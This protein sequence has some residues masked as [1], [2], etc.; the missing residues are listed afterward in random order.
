[1]FELAQRNNVLHTLPC[2][3]LDEMRAAYNFQDLQ[4]FLDLYYAGCAALIKEQV[5]LHFQLSA[6]LMPAHILQS[7]ML[8]SPLLLGG[9][10]NVFTLEIGTAL[11]TRTLGAQVVRHD[12]YS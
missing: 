9:T 5:Q 10:P 7:T 3:T 2:K 11:S 6:M 1:M 12:L 8:K 4:S